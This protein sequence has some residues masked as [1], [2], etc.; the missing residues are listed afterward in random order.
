M[1]R[2]SGRCGSK[3]LEHAQQQV[4]VE[5][6]LVR[7]VD[8]QGVVATQLAIALQL[9]EQDAVRHQLDAAIRAG[10]IVEA[11]LVADG[12]A[13]RGARLLGKAVRQR[14]RGNP[15][16]LRMPDHARHATPGL[17]AELRELR[18]LT[19]ARGP[20]KNDGGIAADRLDDLSP[21]AP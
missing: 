18:R 21:D 4:D 2:R 10:A 13:D 8:D 6:A 16:R 17:E 14:A 19:R 7:L 1:N 20:A 5:T 11:H 12:A 15:S 3:L 9:L